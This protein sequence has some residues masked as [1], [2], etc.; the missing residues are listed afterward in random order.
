MDEAEAASGMR[1]LTTVGSETPL[2]EPLQKI[3][4]S[5]ASEYENDAS[6][7]LS[8]AERPYLDDAIEAAKTAL[9]PAGPE[10][11]N[12]AVAFLAALPAPAMNAADGKM[13]L[14]LYRIGLKD[15]PRDLLA[16]ACETASRECRWRP[17]PAELRAFVAGSLAERQKALRRLVAAK[18]IAPPEPKKEF[19]PFDT[20]AILDQHWPDRDAYR[21]ARALKESSGCAAQ[22]IGG[23]SAAAIAMAKVMLD[24]AKVVEG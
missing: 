20:A 3:L 8:T 22:S 5:A 2:P 10:T 4:R 16:E 7:F 14:Q 11:I 1:T 21:P 9:L 12:K 18:S 6:F 17:S 15:M 24:Q 23:A 19:E 13:V